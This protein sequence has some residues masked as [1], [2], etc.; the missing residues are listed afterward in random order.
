MRPISPV[1]DS[2]ARVSGKA[3]DF[4]NTNETIPPSPMAWSELPFCNAPFTSVTEAES[5]FSAE[6]SVNFAPPV[7]KA[8][9]QVLL[10]R[11]RRHKIGFR[12]PPHIRKSFGR[13]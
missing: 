13:R 1:R 3:A 2:T 9:Q 5:H 10:A 6:S 4:G 8:H 11:D 12:A 7:F